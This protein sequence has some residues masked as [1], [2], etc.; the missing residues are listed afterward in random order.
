M[1]F[2][3]Q[4]PRF[5]VRDDPRISLGVEGSNTMDRWLDPR[6]LARIKQFLSRQVRIPLHLSL[7]FSSCTSLSNYII[8]HVCTSV[9]R[10]M[11][12][13]KT[14]RHLLIQVNTYVYDHVDI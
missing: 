8:H 7:S 9:C 1:E 5:S 6:N 4:N 13:G 14:M 10:R 2:L 3:V 12:N 11:K